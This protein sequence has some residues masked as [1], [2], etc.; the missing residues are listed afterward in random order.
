MKALKEKRVSLRSL[1][2]RG[3]V[4]LSLFALVFASC[5][6]SDSGGDTPTEGTNPPE[7]I[8][9][10]IRSITIL[11][12]P[13]Y[14]SFQGLPPNL[15]G[16]IAEV[17]W[18]DSTVPEVV[19]DHTKFTTVPGYADI[20]TNIGT[21]N[22]IPYGLMYV[23]HTEAQTNELKIPFVVSAS[24]IDITQTSP[25]TWYSDMRPDFSNLIYNVAFEAGWSGIGNNS[26][27]VLPDGQKTP[28]KKISQP[29]TAVYP[30]VNYK[31]A[32]KDKFLTAFIGPDDITGGGTNNA[33]A[34]NM[35]KTN[36]KV[37]NYY[38]VAAV[39]F[40]RFDSPKD[41]V[42]DDLGV[43][44]NT[45]GP[46]LNKRDEQKI[47]NELKASGAKFKVS[48]F[49]PYAN[50]NKTVVKDREIS[51]Q[52]FYANSQWFNQ[53]IGNNT[54][55]AY[56]VKQIIMND[57]GIRDFRAGNASSDPLGLVF[58]LDEDDEI[59]WNVRLDYV[60][61]SYNSSGAYGQFEVPFQM[62]TFGGDLRR[63]KDIPGDVTI[64]GANNPR[65]MTQAELDAIKGKWHLEGQYTKGR[66]SKWFKIG[67]TSQ[68]FYDGYYGSSMGTV[69]WASLNSSYTTADNK[70][71]PGIGDFHPNVS[72]RGVNSLG[73]AEGLTS[74]GGGVRR[75]FPL[76]VY[77]RGG[78][79]LDEDEAITVTLIPYD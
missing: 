9:R 72:A 35:R 69:G 41:Y 22:Q 11:Q 7:V 32:A 26:Y 13:Q 42:D 56:M 75:D 68:M 38:G 2:R 3:L 43:F 30:K 1:L 71:T 44:Y 54:D 64:W 53:L 62:Y 10:T 14:E 24:N 16:L 60:P 5:S 70:Q 79:L 49:D 28:Y 20:A 4:I 29:M 67:L 12:Q 34:T 78:Y 8:T 61:W 63:A 50:G 19:Y 47:Y 51:I 27:G 59:T 48:Y 21:L 57:D 46:N 77:Y 65:A 39:E 36:F 18:S 76:P 6:D 74:A 25:V 58:K 55:N 52:E 15:E 40:L 37:D 23:G 45:S 66:A 33:G 31:D 17:L 73:P